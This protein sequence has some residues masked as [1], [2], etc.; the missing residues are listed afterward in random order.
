MSSNVYQKPFY[1]PPSVSTPFKGS[2]ASGEILLFKDDN[3]NS[4]S[5]KV[6]INS[7][8]YPSGSFFS[9]SGTPLQDNAT[10]IVFNLPIN[11]VCTLCSNLVQNKNPYDFSD[12]GICVDLIGNG[13]VQ[14]INLVAYGANDCLSGGIWRT[15]DLLQGWFQ[16]FQDVDQ[17]GSFATIFLAEWPLST[18]N[19][20]AKWWLQDQ[21][22]SVNYPCLTPPQLLELFDN[23]DG[24]GQSK[25]LGA[26]NPFGTYDIP[27]V[28][29]L[30][31]SGMNDKVSSFEYSLI[32]PVKVAVDDVSV[33]VSAPIQP[34]QTI[35]N[36][37]R[38]TNDSSET[39]PVT[40]K[41]AVGRT[42]DIKNETTQQY[43]T[44]V[45][46]KASV[47]ATAGVPEVASSSLESTL[48]TSFS[49]SDESTQTTENT[50]TL[51]LE[52]SITFNVP[53]ESTYTG[54]WNVE[55]GQVSPTTVTQN[56]CF[57]YNQNL[58]GSQ[59]QKDGTYLLTTP[60]T[61]VIAG[62]IGSSVRFDVK[63]NPIS[64][65]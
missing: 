21:A 47:K 23:T 31:S 40:Q 61:V 5:L 8:E 36:D 17:S 29:N 3:W 10:W 44:T 6:D 39:L 30:S 51:H 59:K 53:A 4:P 60:L 25:K 52:Q 26:S 38:G 19:S 46:I 12:A 42:T 20:I 45:G 35:T 50:D 57:Y 33:S 2:C 16:L 63:S 18:S 49:V 28:V 48:T 22:S 62:N 15:V 55:I 58:P 32:P 13:Q 54:V 34:G 41:V 27:A 37:I 11:V 43:Q 24:T 64:K 9:F 1:V 56:G 65:K 7:P 14:T